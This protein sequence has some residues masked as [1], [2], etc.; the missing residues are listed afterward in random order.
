MKGLK[1][2]WR[3]EPTT[4][5]HAVTSIATLLAALA[6]GLA[7]WEWA[8]IVIMIGLVWFAEAV[9]TAIERLADAVTLE[10][11]PLIGKAKDVASTSVFL[12]SL[13]ATAV[14]ALIFVP[15]ILALIDG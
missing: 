7:R 13:T 3:E 4:R 2:L 15:H 10:H 1:A 6:L 14:G 9:N 12:A 11:H 5:F 8:L